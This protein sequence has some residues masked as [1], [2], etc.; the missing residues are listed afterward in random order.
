VSSQN[1]IYKGDNPY[2]DVKG[3]KK[4]GMT[5]VLLNRTRKDIA[6][7]YEPDNNAVDLWDAWEWIRKI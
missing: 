3:V 5:S 6:L 2:H 7:P 4:I 1:A